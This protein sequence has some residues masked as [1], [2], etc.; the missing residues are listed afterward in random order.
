[1]AGDAGVTGAA[2]ETAG[3]S[4]VGACNEFQDNAATIGLCY[5]FVIMAAHLGMP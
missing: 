5:R 3:A 1:M 4:A 2:G